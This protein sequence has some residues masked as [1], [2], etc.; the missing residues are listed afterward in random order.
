MWTLSVPVSLGDGADPSYST[1]NL[2]PS[3]RSLDSGSGDGD[4]FGP[5]PTW[6][7]EKTVSTL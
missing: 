2:G 7:S 4:K 3:D 1:L 5:V 6:S